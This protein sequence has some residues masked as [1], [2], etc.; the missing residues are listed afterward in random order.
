LKK[1]TVNHPHVILKSN[2][3]TRFKIIHNSLIFNTVHLP[4]VGD[5]DLI[6]GVAGHVP[7]IVE[8]P[9]LLA[10][11]PELVDENA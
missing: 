1:L 6:L 9:V 7:G 4:G 2:T 10:S 8:L 5:K 11:L 3:V